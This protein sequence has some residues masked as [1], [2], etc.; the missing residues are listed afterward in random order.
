MVS[1]PQMDNRHFYRL[2]WLDEEG[3]QVSVTIAQIGKQSHAEVERIQN[4]LDG[5]PFHVD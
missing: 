3:R 1:N 4:A 2:V 5:L